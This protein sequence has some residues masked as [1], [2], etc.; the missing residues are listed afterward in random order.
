LD[1]E[2]IVTQD[3]F[4]ITKSRMDSFYDTEFI[5]P[6]IL[7]ACITRANLFGSNGLI[8]DFKYFKATL[9]ETISKKY[10]KAEQIFI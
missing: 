6:V 10:L 5:V 4:H 9:V 2:T 7:I 3:T 1:R 8:N